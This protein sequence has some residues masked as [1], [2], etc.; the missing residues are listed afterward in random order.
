MSSA[1]TYADVLV[2]GRG[3][4]GCAAARHLARSGAGVVLVG[5]GEPADF[6]RHDGVFASH[7]DEARIVRT[8]ARDLTWARLARRSWA[9]FESLQGES[10]IEFL[11][12]RPGL[13]LVEPGRT[14]VF[15]D[16]VRGLLPELESDVR[17][18][19]DVDTLRAWMPS[20]ALPPGVHG[21]LGKAWPG[22]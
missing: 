9:A 11:H 19:Q 14:S 3:L 8:T 2:I 10:G 16:V 12:R 4:F 17:F 5:P 20:L 6:A 15:L 1:D 7:Y 21:Y 18:T 13:H 22:T